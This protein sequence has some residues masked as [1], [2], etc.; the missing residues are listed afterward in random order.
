MKIH[1]LLIPLIIVVSSCL[2]FPQKSFK[3]LNA[4]EKFFVIKSGKAKIYY[5]IPQKDASII[6]VKGPGKLSIGTRARFNNG[7]TQYDYTIYY[8]IDGGKSNQVNFTNVGKEKEIKFQNNAD[9]VPGLSKKIIIELGPGQH[10]IKFRRGN[11]KPEIIARYMFTKY[12]AK[13]LT[14]VMLSPA[15]PNEPIDLV[16]KENVVHYYRFSQKNPLKINIIGPTIVRVLTRFENHFNMKGRID[17][18]LQLKENGSVIHTYLLSST[19]SDVTTYK[20]EDKLIPGKATEFYIEVPAGK[21]KYTI[22]PIDEDKNNILARVL[23]PKKD[24][25]LED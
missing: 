17:Y 3:P 7:S 12:K 19:F 13:K 23:F 15:P 6:S 8:T 11:D 4:S 9:G 14:W 1:I 2:L 25:K 18:R 20:H 22:I 10:T 16:T 21:H 5:V 24:V